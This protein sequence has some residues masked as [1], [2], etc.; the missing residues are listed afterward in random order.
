MSGRLS[1]SR[2][3]FAVA[4]LG[5]AGGAVAQ[6]SDEVVY[7]VWLQDRGAGEAARL[8][9]DRRAVP[10]LSAAAVDRIKDDVVRRHTARLGAEVLTPFVAAAD[11]A[12]FSVRSAGPLLPWAAVVGPRASMEAFLASRRDVDAFEEDTPG[13]EELEY[14]V[15]S[16]RADWVRTHPTFPVNGSGASVGVLDSG[17]VAQANPYLPA[18]ILFNGTPG[19]QSH[20][21]AVAGQV[22]SSHPVST[23]VAPGVAM[24][25]SAGGSG[26]AGYLTNGQWLYTNGADLVTC[27]LFTGSTTTNVLNLSDRGFD[28]LVRNLGR[29]FVKSCGNQG[30]GGY[31]TTPGRGYN[32]IAVGNYNEGNTSDWADDTMAPS[33]S[34]L[35]PASGAPKPEIAAPGTAITGTTTAAPWIGSNGTGTSF[36]APHVAGAV[37]LLMSQDPIFKTRPELVKAV[38]VATAWNNIE[39]DAVL[40]ELDGA[41]GMDCAAAYRVTEAGRFA[42]G[43]LS[44]ADFTPGYKDYPLDLKAGNLTRVALSWCSNPAD[45][46]ASYSPDGLD[47]IFDLQILAP[48]T[49]AIVATATHPS[50]AWRILQF[51]PT[52]SGLYTAR[53]IPV[54]FQGTTE[55]FGLAASQRFDAD[56]A[57]IGGVAATPV[58]TNLALTLSDPYHP[59]R[60]YFL[61][62]GLSGG[63]YDAGVPLS[64]QVVPL[65][66]DALT[67]FALTPGNGLVTGAAG[68]LSATGQAAATLSVP[69]LPILAGLEVSMVLVTLDAAGVDGVGGVSPRYVA[70]IV[71]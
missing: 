17:G 51:M 31:V 52:V 42:H 20:S 65:L 28:Y 12:G 27:S 10:G 40:S 29:T 9:L 50:A 55:P 3:A 56:V 26:S 24:L 70:T 13:G 54:L 61:G 15:P 33:S 21:T 30:N 59:N 34:G 23:G 68:V 16:V 35:D 22:A 66:P 36:A 2:C 32:S 1:R 39:G 6:T 37:A 11:G 49:G 5:L 48:G 7:H 46:T 45:S 71:P 38:L 44:A 25:S 4:V 63:A 47:A 41:G 19:V 60:A 67:T 18:G 8:E 43:I 62:V 14:S 58:G 57:R 53:L 64:E 69:A